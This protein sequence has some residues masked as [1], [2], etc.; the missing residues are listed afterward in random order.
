MAS[1]KGKDRVVQIPKDA[2][3]KVNLG[4][5][6]AEYDLVRQHPRLF[7]ETPALRAASDQHGTKCIF[8][9]RRGTGKT[10]TTFFI[11]QK[12]E[13][14]TLLLLPSMFSVVD[15]IAKD[16]DFTDVHQRPFK[17]VVGAFKRA[18]L[19][20][21]TKRWVA[22][23][24][25]SFRGSGSGEI[26]RERNSIEQEE[27]DTRV[28]NFLEEGFEAL[29]KGQE[30]DRTKLDGKMKR[31]TNEIAENDGVKFQLTIL[32][33]R[34]DEDWN[35]S[36]NAVTALM[37]LLHAVVE[38][39]AILPVVKMLAF[40]RENMFDRVRELDKEFARL[41][42]AVV[43]LEWT[44]ELLQE[45][46]ERRLQMNLIAKPALGGPT[47]DA[48]FETSSEI[49]SKDLVFQYCQFRPRDILTYCVFAVDD[50]KSKQHSQIKLGDLLSARKRF[51][52]SR[53][54]ELGDEYAENYP[55]LVKVLEKFFGLGRRFTFAAIE[56][57]IK[58]L[59]ADA[60]IKKNCATWIYRNTTPE[61]FNRA[62]LRH[63]IPWNRRSKQGRQLQVT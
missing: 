12:E 49:S 35:G 31:L 34:I 48:F 10:A 23:G 14:H 57:F 55:Q 40:I 56:D 60:E 59:L 41:E 17:T 22:N 11:Q 29:A 9:G 42:T 15:A 16:I 58:K 39:N 5:S 21:I 61:R 6:F 20:E 53:L 51:S 38:L 62:T 2:L 24:A 13:K 54:K 3:K 37:A 26:T 36:N 18:L 4:D 44:R 30:K 27:F 45:F 50:A 28:I 43:S 1:D 63:R 8:V 7:V 25:Y 33:D 52:E 19:C 32:I 47:W 46:I